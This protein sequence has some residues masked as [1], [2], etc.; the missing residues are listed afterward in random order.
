[1]GVNVFCCTVAMRSFTSSMARNWRFDSCF[2]TRTEAEC[3]FLVN[4]THP[5]IFAVLVDD[6]YDASQPPS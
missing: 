3:P 2:F 6:L 1:M 4:V 5:G